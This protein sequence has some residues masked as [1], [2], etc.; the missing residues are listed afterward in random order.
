[1][2]CA[3]IK[4]LADLV[5]CCPLEF[6]TKHVQHGVEQRLGFASSLFILGWI[7]DSGKWFLVCFGRVVNLD[8]Q[9]RL[10]WSYLAR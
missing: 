6:C 7:Q 9:I 3:W 2:I 8:D 5:V 4:R 1:M 10:G